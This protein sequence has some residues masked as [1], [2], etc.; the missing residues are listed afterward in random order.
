[1]NWTLIIALC[2]FIVFM[3]LITATAAEAAIG[4]GMGKVIHAAEI[5][6]FI[7]SAVI[8]FTDPGEHMFILLAVWAYFCYRTIIKAVMNK[9]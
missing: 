1:M 4:A 3:C 5:V 6:V 9:G 2:I 7:L 8:Y